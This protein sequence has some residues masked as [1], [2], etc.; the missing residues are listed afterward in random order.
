MKKYLLLSFLLISFATFVQKVDLDKLDSYFEKTA[1]E[2]E[3]PG[4]STFNSKL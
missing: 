1:K 3:I 2:W 4:M